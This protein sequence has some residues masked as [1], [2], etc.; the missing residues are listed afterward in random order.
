MRWL[1]FDG[2]FFFLNYLLPY[3]LYLAGG[4]SAPPRLPWIHVDIFV[5]PYTLYL[6]GGCSHP[7][8]PPELKIHERFNF[9]NPGAP[10][11]VWGCGAPPARYKV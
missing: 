6:A 5:L 2:I 4:C 7:P 10:G 3:T 8:D 9:S 11:R 1:L